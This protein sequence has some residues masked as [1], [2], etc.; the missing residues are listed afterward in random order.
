MSDG[1]RRRSVTCGLFFDDSL[2]YSLSKIAESKCMAALA[3]DA[4]CNH[5]SLDDD[6]D[7]DDILL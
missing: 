4:R 1:R 2:R 3:G 6:D 7:D 5:S